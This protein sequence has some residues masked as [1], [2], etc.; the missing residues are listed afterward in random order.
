MT[1]KLLTFSGIPQVDGIVNITVSDTNGNTKTVH[2]TILIGNDIAAIVSGLTALIT[3]TNFVPVIYN[4]DSFYVKSPNGY[5]VTTTGNIT[6]P[7]SQQ[8]DA[9]TFSFNEKRNGY[10]SFY[11]YKP[12]WITSAEDIIYTWL[13]GQ[14][15]VHNNT[16]QYCNFYGVQYAVSI[17]LVF[18][19]NLFEKKTWLNVAELATAIWSCP[20]IYSNVMS[21]GTQRQ[22]TELVESRFATLESMFHAAILRDANSRKG[23]FNGDTIKG[24]YLVVKFLK[25][26]ASE[27]I[28]LSQVDISFIDSPLT[29]K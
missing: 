5:V 25:E 6:S 4:L 26:S 8:I 21:Y 11:D 7:S 13:N 22:E 20:I 1:Y 14:L 3:D 16:N 28:Q 10:C 29:N 18:N 24:N 9:Y 15:W 2:Y 12:E 23:L 19:M 17:T 27:L